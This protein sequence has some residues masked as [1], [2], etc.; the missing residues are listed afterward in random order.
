MNDDVKLRMY[1]F[2]QIS[3]EDVLIFDTE[4]GWCFKDQNQDVGGP[5][6]D[7]QKTEGGI[8]V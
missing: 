5:D 1:G 2:L 6:R 3:N 8:S 7:Y 4:G